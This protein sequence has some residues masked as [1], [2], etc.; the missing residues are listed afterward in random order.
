MTDNHHDELEY[1]EP[2]E[3]FYLLWV[4]LEEERPPESIAIAIRQ[5]MQMWIDLMNA[6]YDHAPE[7]IDAAREN[8]TEQLTP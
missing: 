4:Y 8:K 2:P 1:R 7:P 5:A 6:E 3:W